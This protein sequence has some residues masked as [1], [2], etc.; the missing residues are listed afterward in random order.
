VAEGGPAGIHLAE[1]AVETAFLR[2]GDGAWAAFLER[3]GLGHVQ[4]APPGESPVAYLEHLGA[5]H[6]RLIAAHCVQVDAGDA[7]TLARRGVHVALCPRS[8][9]RLGVGRPPLPLLL[10]AGANVCVGTDSLA[11]APT[12]NVLDDVA[13]LHRMFP[14]VAAA[15][16]LELATVNGAAA[17]GIEDLGTIGPGMAA[18]MAYAPSRARVSD[19]EGF[20]VS[21]EARLRPV[22]A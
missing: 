20:L 5:L 17:L 22:A 3:R 9:D 8:N 14:D 11:S 2:E 13:A 16:L 7:R 18:R 4:A 19:P 1:S 12:L 10:D 6:A 15:T 21:G